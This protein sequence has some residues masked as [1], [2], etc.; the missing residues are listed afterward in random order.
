MR[1]DADSF[2]GRKDELARLK[3]AVKRAESGV[4]WV[5]GPAGIGKSYLLA[6]LAANLGNALGTWRIFWRFK[7]SDIARCTRVAFLRHAVERLAGLLGRVDVVASQDPKELDDQFETLLDA[8]S[9][10]RVAQEEPAPSR[11]V[12]AR[13]P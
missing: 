1:D 4:L 9:S 12:R 6:K 5:G 2:L 13:R 7:A 10:V 8:A 3:D 11:G